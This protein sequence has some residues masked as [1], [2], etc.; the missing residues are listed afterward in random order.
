MWELAAL[1]ERSRIEANGATSPAPPA[2]KA[3]R[4]RVASSRS[5]A[6]SPGSSTG[7]VAIS[8]TTA[9]R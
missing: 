5:A 9:G 2:S 8:G 6:T 4:S 7:T 1:S 3:V